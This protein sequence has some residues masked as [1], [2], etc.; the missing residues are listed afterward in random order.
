MS[1]KAKDIPPMDRISRTKYILS[2]IVRWMKK[3]NKSILVI[4]L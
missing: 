2:H 3:L 1:A 4:H